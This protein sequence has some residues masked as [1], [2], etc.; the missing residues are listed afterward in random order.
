M[1]ARV[2]HCPIGVIQCNLCGC[3]HFKLLGFVE[4]NKDLCKIF[5][6]GQSCSI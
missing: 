1:C 6:V 5:E 2:V 3:V 4:G